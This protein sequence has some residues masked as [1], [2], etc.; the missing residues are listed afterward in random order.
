MR[1]PAPS[2][3]HRRQ[4]EGWLFSRMGVRAVMG[5]GRALIALLGV[6]VLGVTTAAVAVPGSLVIRNVTVISPERDDRLSQASVPIY[7]YCAQTLRRLSRP[8]IP[9]N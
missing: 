5:L 7:C 2:A 3:G 4:S 8:T 1:L 6:C 9:S